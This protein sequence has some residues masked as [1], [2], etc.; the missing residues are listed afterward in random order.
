MDIEEITNEMVRDVQYKF[1][2]RFFYQT[3]LLAYIVVYEVSC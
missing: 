1:E 3:R 2:G